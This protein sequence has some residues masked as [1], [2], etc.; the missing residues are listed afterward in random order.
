MGILVMVFGFLGFNISSNLS[1]VAE[2]DGTV[3]T[4]AGFNTFLSGMTAAVSALFFD[5][6]LPVGGGHWSY[7]NMA[8]GALIGMA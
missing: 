3:I 2:G 6:F 1:I 7:V 4:Y 5:R 8:N